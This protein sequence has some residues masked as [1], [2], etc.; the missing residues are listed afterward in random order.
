MFGEAERA[1]ARE[2]LRETRKLTLHV[3]AKI[4]YRIIR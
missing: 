1:T 3:G 2:E 4:I